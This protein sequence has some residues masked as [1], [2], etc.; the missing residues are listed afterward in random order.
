[1]T[2]I[3]LIYLIIAL[4]CVGLGT[5]GIFLP[6]L[7]TTPFYLLAAFLFTKSSSR[8]ENWFVNTNLYKDHMKKIRDRNDLTVKEKLSI[9][10][11]ISVL[12]ILGL[13]FMR[14]LVLPRII[15]LIIWILHVVYFGFIISTETKNT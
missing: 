10:I 1:M 6:I 15:L 7:P 12:M 3:K 9:L 4:I 8:L 13:Y 14:H 11:P 5:V 2:I